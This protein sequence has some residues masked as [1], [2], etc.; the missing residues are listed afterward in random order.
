[1]RTRLGQAQVESKKC[2]Y[3]IN[4]SSK[5]AI[6]ETNSHSI[7]Q[8]DQKNCH[9]DS[10]ANID[11]DP[12]LMSGD[13]RHWMV[14]TTHPPMDGTTRKPPA[15]EETITGTEIC[16]I[17]LESKDGLK[18][19]NQLKTLTNASDNT[20]STASYNKHDMTLHQQ[21]KSNSQT[22]VLLQCLGGPMDAPRPH[23]TD[24]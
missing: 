20:K 19:P 23:L 15:G 2:G 22:G 17:I 12:G 4:Q 3:I 1:M 5:E 7:N 9:C 11:S 8:V 21:I 16:E 14:F 10:L 13:R 18:P 6:N 24:K